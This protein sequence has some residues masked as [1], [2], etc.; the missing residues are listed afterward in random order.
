MHVECV[1]RQM[2]VCPRV[3]GVMCAACSS[4]VALLW[5]GVMDPSGGNVACTVAR[6]RAPLST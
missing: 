2:V 3:L 1:S 5:V 4:I 6:G